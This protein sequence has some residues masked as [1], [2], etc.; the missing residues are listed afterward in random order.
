M[1]EYLFILTCS[2]YRTSRNYAYDTRITVILTEITDV[3]KHAGSFVSFFNK[4]E[5]LWANNLVEVFC[6]TGIR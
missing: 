3:L 2:I 4:K 5:G 1:N 6:A